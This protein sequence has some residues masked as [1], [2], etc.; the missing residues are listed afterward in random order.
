MTQC[1]NPDCLQINPEETQYCQECGAQLLLADRYR[2]LRILGKGGFGRT[3]LAVDQSK[4]QN[5][6]CVIK[7]FLPDIKSKKG[8]YKA[9][10]LFKREAMRLNELGKENC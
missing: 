4:P 5:N 7:Q 10:E 1:L 3:F 2:A 9:A 6:L 8:L